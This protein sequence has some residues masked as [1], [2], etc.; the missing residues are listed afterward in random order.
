MD[1]SFQIL[2]TRQHPSW[3][4]ILFTASS[5]PLL[6]RW[7]RQ[8][9][10]TPASCHA[11]LNSERR[12][13][14]CRG[15]LTP[16]SPTDKT[17]QPQQT[18]LAVLFGDFVFETDLNENS[19]DTDLERVTLA[20]NLNNWIRG[21]HAVRDPNHHYERE[22]LSNI[23]SYVNICPSNSKIAADRSICI[24]STRRR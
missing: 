8:P 18:P 12:E 7:M 23:A 24:R 22:M 3:R 10:S 9:S 4:K 1:D 17:V 6:R 2:D 16:S 21:A 20:L 19:D 11:L 15:R 5:V 13:R 14:S